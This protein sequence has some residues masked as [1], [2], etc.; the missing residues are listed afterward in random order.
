MDGAH[1]QHGWNGYD[2]IPMKDQA[3]P[4]YN[5]EVSPWPEEWEGPFAAC[6]SL[7]SALF[8]RNSF[9][10]NNNLDMARWGREAMHPR[11]HANTPYMGLWL[12]MI[13]RFLDRTNG[14]GIP[15]PGPP[16]S[17]PQ[18]SK[19]VTRAELI[20]GHIPIIDEA[21]LS[22]A[23]AVEARAAEEAVP[24]FGFPGDD[25]FYRSTDYPEGEIATVK[26]KF[27][28]GE[29]VRVALQYGS[30]HS[31][32]YPIYRGKVGRIIQDY[33]LAAPRF[34]STGAAIFQPVYT[35]PYPDIQSRGRQTFLVPLYS[36]RFKARDIWGE[37]Y[38]EPDTCLYAD[39]WEPYLEPL[40][41]RGERDDDSDSDSDS[42][43]HGRRRRG[44]N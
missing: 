21:T 30:G 27:R 19:P 5:G 16:S 10:L 40:R 6:Y 35:K 15:L 13:A 7:T 2:E 31:R 24:G 14:E 43:R 17:P 1:N 42:G 41:D 34:D 9:P 26:R 28:V 25:G 37:N 20:D 11:N 32:Q 4:V 29:R 8:E 3:E 12:G 36:V 39:M 44:R 33:G 23:A 18:S 38:A 22:R